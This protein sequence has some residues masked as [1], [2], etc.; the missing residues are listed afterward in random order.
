MR[1]LLVKDYD[2]VA[3]A[4]NPPSGRHRM[5]SATG[6]PRAGKSWF[7]PVEVIPLDLRLQMWTVSSCAGSSGNTETRCGLA[8]G[9]VGDRILGLRTG[10]DD[11]L[12][13]FDEWVNSWPG[14]M[15]CCGRVTGSAEAIRVN[16]AEVRTGGFVVRERTADFAFP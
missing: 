11:C 5:S 12:I 8:Q 13:K 14:F 2:R 15:P 1:V 10:V 6:C 7:A 3:A 9:T 4:W 16:D